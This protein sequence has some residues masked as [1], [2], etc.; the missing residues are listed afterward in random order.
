MN[1]Y[2]EKA[3]QT[4]DPLVRRLFIAKGEGLNQGLTYRKEEFNK[5][6]AQFDLLQKDFKA[7]KKQIRDFERSWVREIQDLQGGHHAV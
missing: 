2:F 5:L 1:P 3:E 7:L 4:D 6:S